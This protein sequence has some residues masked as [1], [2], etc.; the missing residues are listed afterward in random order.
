[1]DRLA[2][3]L[4]DYDR[5]DH[6]RRLAVSLSS[7][8]LWYVEQGLRVFPL[9]PSLKTPHKGTRGVLEASTDPSVVRKWWES[10]PRSNVGVAT[11]HLV[12]VIDVD[13]PE[14]V[15]SWANLSGL[16][17][18]VGKVSTPRPGGIHLYVPTTGGDR[19]NAARIAAGIDYR[20]L[21]GYVV[22]PPSVNTEGRRYEWLS[23]LDLSQLPE[24]RT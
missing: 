13:G 1:M 16:P 12:D 21:G 20:G 2:S 6:A 10:E 7:A 22:A 4:D 17:P 23:P 9:R 8:A 24:V 18:I 14:G 11:G 5:R 3:W 19:R 15:V